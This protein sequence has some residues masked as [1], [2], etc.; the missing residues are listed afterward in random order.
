APRAAPLRLRPA[1]GRDGAPARSGAGGAPGRPRPDG[2]APG[3]RAGADESSAV[4]A[5][6]Y[7]GLRGAVAA[8]AGD[9]A[10]AGTRLARA[11]R[12]GRRGSAGRER[13]AAAPDGE[14]SGVPPRG[15]APARRGLAARPGAAE[16]LALRG[17]GGAR[18]PERR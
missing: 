17:R 16:P 12:S 7:L 18:E 5:R 4:L 8:A 11:A 13:A 10:A 1:P 15:G 3:A 14:P 6:Q 9:G 2:H